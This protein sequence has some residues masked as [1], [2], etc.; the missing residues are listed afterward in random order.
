MGNPPVCARC[1]IKGPTCCKTTASADDFCFPVSEREERLILMH[2]G[3]GTVCTAVNSALFLQRIRS[4]F[5]KERREAAAVF[6]PNGSHRRLVLTGEGKCVLLTPEGCLLPR[7]ARPL[8]C[9]LFPFWV[10]DERLALL[11]HDGCLA[12]EECRSIG[13]LLRLFRTSAEE[14]LSIHRSL[15]LFWHIDNET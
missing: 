10:V 15:R 12:Q 13:D 8:Y 2:A 5:P 7:E 4:L 1:A 3:E 11:S 14:V 6:P 9:R